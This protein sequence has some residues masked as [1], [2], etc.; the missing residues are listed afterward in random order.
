MTRSKPIEFRGS[1]LA[2][3][4]KLP[5]GARRDAGYQL[6][7]VQYGKDPDDWKPLP[8]IGRNV[9]E[10]RIWEAAGTFRV[11]YVATLPDA[12]Y[13]LHCFRKTTQRTSKLDI[14]LA[15][16]RFRALMKEHRR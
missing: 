9:K 15:A 1:S 14:D 3:L 6:A 12:V 13:V 10:L 7:K 2:D 5:E 16:A 4:R 11:I 8:A